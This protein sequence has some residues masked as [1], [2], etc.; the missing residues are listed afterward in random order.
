MVVEVETEMIDP[1]SFNAGFEAGK[2]A[3]VAIVQEARA[4]ER[5]TDF[6]SIIYGIECLPVLPPPSELLT[7]DQV[8]EELNALVAA[9]KANP[10]V[11]GAIVVAFNADGVMPSVVLRDLRLEKVTRYRRLP[12]KESDE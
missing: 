9:G 5:D 11:R 4:G 7:S 1:E 12:P 2:K 8:F 6:R 10:I 3:A